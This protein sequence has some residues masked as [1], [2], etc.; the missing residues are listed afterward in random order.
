MRA[1]VIAK[2]APIAMACATAIGVLL[3]AANADP[4]G[5]KAKTSGRMVQPSGQSGPQMSGTS[6]RF[7]Q[8]W[9]SKVTR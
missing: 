4:A 6:P 5:G 2:L 1:S 8:G 9:P 7:R 3:I